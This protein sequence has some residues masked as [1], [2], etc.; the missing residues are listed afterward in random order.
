[1][2]KE[3]LAEY[4][5][6]FYEELAKENQRQKAQELAEAHKETGF[7]LFC[8]E[9]LSTGRRFCDADCR[10]DFEREE[11]RQKFNRKLED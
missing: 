1:M 5:I 8:S 10:D 7:C 3:Q 11:A 2:N 4:T 6:S 9:P